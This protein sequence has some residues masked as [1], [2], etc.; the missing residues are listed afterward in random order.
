MPSDSHLR[1]ATCNQ[2]RLAE[3]TDLA[4]CRGGEPGSLRG[5]LGSLQ[6]VWSEMEEALEESV[7]WRSETA[8]LPGVAEKVKDWQAPQGLGFGDNKRR[9]NHALRISL[10]ACTHLQGPKTRLS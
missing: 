4:P 9:G 3:V 7:E 10:G 2:I 8:G 5:L 1:V 6:A